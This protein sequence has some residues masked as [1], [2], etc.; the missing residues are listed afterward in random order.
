MEDWRWEQQGRTDWAVLFLVS[1]QIEKWGASETLLYFAH[2]DQVQMTASFTS[3]EAFYYTGRHGMSD[4][5]HLVRDGHGVLPLFSWISP[6]HHVQDR[7]FLFVCF[8]RTS[9]RPLSSIETV[10][11][12]AF[13]YRVT[14]TWYT[15]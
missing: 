14:R 13:M 8:Y 6:K 2:D 3:K 15:V 11:L 10:S 9:R 4:G 7:T 12:I 5:E 1:G